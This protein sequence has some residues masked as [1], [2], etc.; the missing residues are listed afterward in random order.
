[1]I[2]LKTDNDINLQSK[3]SKSSFV[4]LVFAGLLMSILFR[5]DS[6]SGILY[7]LSSFIALIIML[8]VLV[9]PL[10]KLIYP[11]FI[12][13]VSMP[14]VTQSYNQI[15]A[16]GYI[17]VASPWQ[18]TIGPLTPAILIFFSLFI[19]LCRLFKMPKKN[20]YNYIFILFIIVIPIIS[21]WF[22]FFQNSISRFISDAKIPIYFL[23]GLI[24]F[25]GYYKRFPSQLKIS[26]QIFLALAAGSFLLD[27]IK[28]FFY[29]T[30]SLSSATYTS[31]SFDSAKGLI[32][33][34][35]F[36][37]IANV[38]QKKKIFLNSFIVFIS[39][40]M[41]IAFQTRWLIITF[42]LGL[43]IIFIFLGFKKMIIN[44]T[45][46]ILFLAL[47]FPLYQLMYPE[48]IRIFLLRFS[49]FNDLSTIG[50]ESEVVRVASII[51]SINLLW[52]N[53]AFLTGMGYGSWYDDSYFPMLN[54]SN[55]AFDDDSL[56]SGKYYRVHDFFFHFLFKFGIIGTF[57]YISAFIKPIRQLWKLGPYIRSN[58]NALKTSIVLIGLLP[59]V[60]TYM[61]WTGKGLL[62]S[63]LFIVLAYE[64]VKFFINQLKI[65][66]SSKV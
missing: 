3:L 8:S 25:S 51:N 27:F 29:S 61:Y 45:L 40:F 33:I 56:L 7:W 23:S 42:V 26:C 55:S 35:T 20:P 48:T 64:W 30:N 18:F 65:E 6:S 44:S 5:I 57:L 9:L 63:A 1:L 59:L 49:F 50:T 28:L 36:L 21:I 34:F 41:L 11:L 4:L 32:S 22:G 58:P 19:T 53:N 52:E 37:A 46:L 10:K 54:L 17:T 38:I 31:L 60:V 47:S 2:N 16:F 12:L 15:D 39:L 62:F 24:I 43:F 14:D 66:N 13:I